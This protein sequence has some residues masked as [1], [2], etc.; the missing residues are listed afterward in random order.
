VEAGKRFRKPVAVLYLGGQPSPGTERLVSKED[1]PFF[2]SPQECVKALG[3]LIR[4]SQCL[5]RTQEL[6]PFELPRTGKEK[7][8]DAIRGA[9]SYITEVEREKI[10]AAYGIPT[11]SEKIASSPKE[12]MDIAASFG[13]PVALKVESPEILHKTELGGVELHIHNSSELEEAY[14]RIINRLREASP[15]LNARGVLVQEM[16]TDHVAEVI[17]GVTQDSQFGPTIMFGLGGLM[18]EALGDVSFR[19]CPV[20]LTSA[21]EMVRE[22]RGYRILNG[23]RGKPKA[24]IAALEETIVRLSHLA[25]DL[26]GS[27][28]DIEINPLL[29]L[30]EG[31]GVKVVDSIVILQ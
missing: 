3:N 7:A 18:V 1:L 19:I 31:K 27:I 16:V 11:V 6:V 14:S 21:K 2:F 13:Y 22:V 12:A 29:V 4:Y 10:L 17:V 8:L 28:R 30:P 20:N 23:F 5:R 24:D 15:N 25:V 9:V 26:G